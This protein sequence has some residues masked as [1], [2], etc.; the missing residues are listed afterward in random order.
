MAFVVLTLNSIIPTYCPTNYVTKYFYFYVELEYSCK[1]D[2]I[3]K[4]FYEHIDIYNTVP[5]YIILSY[6]CFTL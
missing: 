5:I 2:S 6:H 1:I 3:L 4:V